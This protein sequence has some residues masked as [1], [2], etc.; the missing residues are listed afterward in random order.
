MCEGH[1]HSQWILEECRPG[2]SSCL[3]SRLGSCTRRAGILKEL[4]LVVPSTIQLELL[5][6]MLHVTDEVSGDAPSQAARKE[7]TAKPRNL[8]M[9][10]CI[11]ASYSFIRVLSCLFSYR[12]VWFSSIKWALNRSISD[13]KASVIFCIQW[14]VPRS[15]RLYANLA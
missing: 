10:D 14:L 7:R 15:D 9:I 13:S 12:S 2:W 3:T 5:C 8:A 6:R 4:R 1:L 11:V